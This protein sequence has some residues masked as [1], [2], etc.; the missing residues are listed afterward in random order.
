MY[1]DYL[2]SGNGMFG[3]IESIGTRHVGP[4]SFF[5]VQM[6]C[7]WLIAC[8]DCWVPDSSL[9]HCSF[10]RTHG[11]LCVGGWAPCRM[12]S[13]SLVEIWMYQDVGLKFRPI[14]VSWWSEIF[15]HISI[16]MKLNNYLVF[17]FMRN[18]EK[19]YSKITFIV[20]TKK[21]CSGG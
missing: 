9:E 1:M 4:W 18:E 12:S 11:G 15:V 19:L 6:V 20:G 16:G 13:Y 2:G 7:K 5:F 3:A 14:E 21:R 10:G 17:F 8:V